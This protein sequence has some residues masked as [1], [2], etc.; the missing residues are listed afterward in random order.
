M[1]VNYLYEKNYTAAYQYAHI[2]ATKY[3]NNSSF[4][5]YFGFCQYSLGML[6]GYDSTY[7]M[8]LSR[9][10]ERREGYTIKQAREAMYF[11]GLSQL[12]RRGGNLDSALYYLY[13]SNLLSRKITPEEVTWWIAKSELY[14]GMA[15]DAKG[16]RKNALMMY[17]RVLQIKDISGTHNEA[18]RYLGSPYRQ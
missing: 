7:R 18:N 8:M 11:L 5:H 2:L 14:M 9:A 6:D 15:Y 16:D 17:N 12:N 3:P 4:L 1:K 10:R 13:N